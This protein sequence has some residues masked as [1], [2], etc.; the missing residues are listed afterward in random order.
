MTN[1]LT[2]ANRHFGITALT[3]ENFKAVR[4][5]C[6]VEFKPITLLFGPNSAGKS[7]ILQAMQFMRELLERQ[8]ADA[9]RTI[10]GGD[11]VDLGGFRNFIQ[12]HD[13]SRPVTVRIDFSLG[14]AAL[15][16]YGRITVDE[17]DSS[18]LRKDI[19]DNGIGDVRS[20]WVKVTCQWNED[21][22][23]PFITRYEVGLNGQRIA[24]ISSEVESSPCINF[25][26]FDHPLFLRFDEAEGVKSPEDNSARQELKMVY[27]FLS[28]RAASVSSFEG[29]QLDEL[30]GD[31]AIPPFGRMLPLS[32]SL[33][34]ESGQIA[35]DLFSFL[36]SQI[37]VGPGEL[38]L[39]LLKGIRYLGPIRDVPPRNFVPQTSPDEARWASGLAAWDILFTSYDHDMHMGN[40]FFKD[41]NRMLG[42][43]D[44]LN[45]GYSLDLSEVYEI[46][47]D[48]MI[49]QHLR[50]LRSDGGP[51]ADTGQLFRIPVL[52][53]LE[54]LQSHRRLLL[55]DNVNDT[56]VKPQDVGVGISQVLP[57][58]VG[59]M[60][61]K[62]SIFAVEQPELH[63]HPRI[64]CSLGDVFAREA[65]KDDGRIFLIETH[66]EHLIL[67]LLHR[68]RQTTDN[69]CPPDR[70]SLRADQVAVY[71]IEGSSDGLRATSIPVTDDGD[72][73]AKWPDGFFSERVEELM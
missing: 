3:V 63:I 59:A 13:P 48:S 44:E 41:V 23:R 64:Q 24:E 27:S 37:L 16:T 18:D 34:E 43:E 40:A 1:E 32:V 56:D 33:E 9:D 12:Q 42:K 62:C 73:G 15:S 65:N 68:I 72:F 66:S 52:S 8:N 20:A 45:L 26:D 11:S 31:G 6:R 21:K 4:S 38:L 50:M 53:E 35:T 2:T 17:A 51:E 47:D 55:H 46:K 14:D 60:A 19:A 10:G 39:R 36:V 30:K 61:P 58:V 7:T 54:R 49:M 5:A 57:V 28:N 67:R 25:I 71:Y 29:V 69:E 70:P 22:H